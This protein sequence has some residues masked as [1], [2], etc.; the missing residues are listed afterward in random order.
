[1]MKLFVLCVLGYIAQ[2]IIVALVIQLIEKQ[3]RW[4][5]EQQSRWFW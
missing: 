5:N 2:V 3:S 4:L 1:M